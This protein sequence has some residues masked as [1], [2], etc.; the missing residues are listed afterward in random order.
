[1]SRKA[2]NVLQGK[3]NHPG[4]GSKKRMWNLLPVKG[5]TKESKQWEKMRADM[6]VIYEKDRVDNKN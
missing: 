4:N 5:Q 6:C 2:R 1:M 3:K